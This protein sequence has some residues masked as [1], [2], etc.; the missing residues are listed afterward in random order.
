MRLIQVTPGVIPI[1]P[2][3]WGAVEK[4]I[5]EYK[6]V[7]DKLGYQ[8]DILYTDDVKKSDNQIVHVHM[9]NL[10]NILNSRGIDYVYS[11]HDH[12]VEH[13]GK[14]Y[15]TVIDIALNLLT[16]SSYRRGHNNRE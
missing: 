6:L 1:P 16:R 5:W 11:L 15:S 13:F 7:L 2:N 9:A 12:H 8:T 10:A 14:D 3:G 4:I